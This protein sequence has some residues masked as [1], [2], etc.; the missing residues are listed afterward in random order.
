MAASLMGVSTGERLKNALER[1][2][3]TKN[4]QTTTEI[5]SEMFAKIRTFAHSSNEHM[6]EVVQVFNSFKSTAAEILASNEYA[7]LPESIFTILG[8][9]SF[10]SAQL[11]H[12]ATQTLEAID[13]EVAR[14]ADSEK[15]ATLLLSKL[16]I[17]TAVKDEERFREVEKE[18]IYM[19]KDLLKID[20][21]FVGKPGIMY[22][23]QT[24]AVPIISCKVDTFFAPIPAP[25]S[26]LDSLEKDLK[27]GDRYFIF[28]Q[29]EREIHNLTNHQLKLLL[30]SAKHL[31][32]DTSPTAQNQQNILQYVA[33]I[34]KTVLAENNE[35]FTAEALLV[36]AQTLHDRPLAALALI[37]HAVDQTSELS[38]P[39]ERELLFASA[40]V[41]MGAHVVAIPIFETHG[42]I[43]QLI[44]SMCLVQRKKEVI[45]LL[46]A[47]IKETREKLDVQKLASEA[48]A[49]FS[50]AASTPTTTAATF[51]QIE[52]ARLLH[53]LGEVQKC[54]DTLK[55]A[56][57]LLK[58]PKYAK[59]LSTHLILQGKAAE[60]AVILK[61]YYFEVEDRDSLL[62]L[63]LSHIQ[64]QQY[65][66]AEKILRLSLKLNSGD[67][68]TETAFHAVLIQQEK[69]E[70]LLQILLGKITAY[71]RNFTQEC[72]H[73]FT[74]SFSFAYYEYTAKAIVHIYTKTKKLPTPWIEKLLLAAK[75][76]AKAKE[77]L[78]DALSQM[79]TLDTIPTIKLL[80]TDT[81][82]TTS[83]TIHYAARKRL[84]ED[85]IKH[86]DYN[87]GYSNLEAM[88]TLA[89]DVYEQDFQDTLH[90]FFTTFQS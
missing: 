1:Y 68:K 10:Q 9:V 22:Q 45:P 12:Y 8:S 44:Q 51:L 53:T 23:G 83:T 87:Q 14:T 11:L 38:T 78:L 65:S 54:T 39:R 84:I 24:E 90:A 61:D 76:D 50:T 43:D 46:E 34:C 35:C 55:E 4:A 7:T 47:R 52:L 42:E 21:S 32:L 75:T 66:E 20:W 28:P 33:A 73:L 67:E 49:L 27:S 15:V 18:T 85:A 25:V 3:A 31:L 17:A 77:A 19:L 88:K 81:L 74:Y 26:A 79:K 64:T 82:P 58:T 62:L 2:K 36:Y 71:S 13:E 30:L 48:S 69:I 56:F 89:G 41:R 59:T 70:E 63:A 37:E 72:T 16:K 29:E 57:M 5:Q 40:M 60:A 80:L 6:I 86:K